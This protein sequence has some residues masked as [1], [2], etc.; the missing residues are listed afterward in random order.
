LTFAGTLNAAGGLSGNGTYPHGGDGTIIPGDLFIASKSA[1]PAVVVAGQPL[2]YTLRVGNYSTATITAHITD[3]LPN[4]VTPGGVRTWTAV[5]PAGG[6][7]TQ[8][9]TVTVSGG[10]SGSLTNRLD[11]TA[12]GVTRQFVLQTPLQDAPIAGLSAGNSGPT[13]QSVPTTLSAAVASGS[14]VQYSWDLGDGATAGGASVSH[15]YAV[16]GTYTATVTAVNSVSSAVTHTVV[17]ILPRPAFAGVAWLDADGDG[18]VGPG[19]AGLD[20]VSITAVSGAGSGSTTS[21]NGGAW[22]LDGLPAGIY[23]LSASLPGHDPT[24]PNPATLSLPTAG[25]AQVPFGFRAALPPGA[26]QIAGRLFND[27]DGD[28]LPA[29]AEATFAGQTI[30]LLQNGAVLNTTTTDASGYYAFASLAPGTYAVR[31]TAPGGYYP[32][33]VQRLDVV[34]SGGSQATAHL[35]VGLGGTLGGA[36]AE[37]G[38]AGVAGATL[39]LAQNGSVLQTTATAADGSYAFGPLP[40]GDYDLSLALPAG[41]LPI[42]GITTRSVAVANNAASIE[43]WTLSRLGR[44][45]VQVY[46]F[47]YNVGNVPIGGVAVTATNGIS[48]LLGSTDYNGDVLWRDLPPGQYTVTPDP[49]TL[50]AG[51]TVSPAARTV[52]VANDTS[53]LASFSV[54]NDRIIL[55][56]CATGGTLRYANFPCTVAAY[57]AAGALVD[58]ASSPAGGLVTLP[59]LPV[60]SYEVRIEPANASWPVHA[61]MVVVASSTVAT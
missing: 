3:T 12:N 19:E 25:S 48:T 16:S 57:D 56:Y 34:V 4:A 28:S 11:V 36:V 27:Q 58:S 31:G 47:V 37:V 15:V 13:V 45:R 8:L 38:G 1:S 53:A 9:I 24:T 23:A 51:A 55:A 18:A 39:M 22:R 50:P 5:I 46:D 29:P 35:P 30:T 60:G 42:D 41:L 20:G 61:E 7:W 21:A 44:L 2:T 17:T 40:P 59:N 10:A 33:P 32:N 43:N 14:G 26:G 49:A 6:A 54:S 52:A